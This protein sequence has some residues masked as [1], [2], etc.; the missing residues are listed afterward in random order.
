M[1]TE[2]ENKAVAIFEFKSGKHR[3]FMPTSENGLYLEWLDY[4]GM[5]LS[6][7]TSHNS[8]DKMKFYDY[9]IKNN[10]AKVIKSPHNL[11]HVWHV[12]MCEDC[13]KTGGRIF[14][15]SQATFNEHFRTV[16]V[17]KIFTFPSA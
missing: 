2:L 13:E 8:I 3:A 15:H 11:Y 5:Y 10:L 4:D 7:A 9:C 1:S 17:D 14:D 12:C 6:G 16:P